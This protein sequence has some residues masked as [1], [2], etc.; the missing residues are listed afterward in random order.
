MVNLWWSRSM[1]GL[2]YYINLPWRLL[3]CKPRTTA[4]VALWTPPGCVFVVPW[5]CSCTQVSACWR[6]APAGPRTPQTSWWRTWWMSAWAPWD[7]GSLVGPLPMVQSE[8]T[9]V[10]MALLDGMESWL[11]ESSEICVLMQRAQWKI[12]VYWVY[13]VWNSLNIVRL[14]MNFLQCPAV[15]FAVHLGGFAGFDFY[16]QDKT[17]GIITPA[18]CSAA[19]CQSTMFLGGCKHLGVFKTRGYNK[20]I[21]LLL[22]YY[23]MKVTR[24]LFLC[25]H[26][27][28]RSLESTQTPMFYPALKIPQKSMFD[29]KNT[30]SNEKPSLVMLRYLFKRP[31][32]GWAG[33][34]SGP[35][36]LLVPPLWV[37]PW[38]NVWRAP[39]TPSS[40]FWWRA[41][42][43]QLS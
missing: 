32:K 17:T 7:G 4:W 1:S 15:P 21:Q 12:E 18:S 34:S 27:P 39:P 38:R 37:A 35:F 8:S 28:F 6:P 36:A 29:F 41:S 2:S 23:N 9:M 19:G 22:N 13:W 31:E 10:A 20:S 5:W 33:S 25:C 30:N 11:F 26:G 16:T 24:E 42:S 14:G 43:T 40:P 3:P